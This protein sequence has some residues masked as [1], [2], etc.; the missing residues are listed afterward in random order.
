MFMITTNGKCPWSFVIHIFRIGQPSHGGDRNTVED[1]VSTYP[2]GTIGS[3]VLI[4]LILG[5][6]VSALSQISCIC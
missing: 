3:V 2:L 4:N 1:M 5:F 6:H